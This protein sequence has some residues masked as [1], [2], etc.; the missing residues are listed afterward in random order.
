MRT[1]IRA[2]LLVVAAALM[3]LQVAQPAS[4]HLV[5]R[6][7]FENITP[8]LHQYERRQAGATA[9]PSPVQNTANPAQTAGTGCKVNGDCATGL[10]DAGRC[11]PQKG[12][13][14][15]N[16]FCTSDAQ[17]K[18]TSYC[19]RGACQDIKLDGA[20]CYKDSGC[21]SGFCVNKKCIAAA[22]Q[23]IN[24]GCT[25]SAQCTGGAFCSNGKCQT[26]KP[27]GSYCYKD[28]GCTS[29]Y[30]V[31]NKCSSRGL[32][33]LNQFCAKNAD[34]KSNFCFRSACRAKRAR[35][36]PCTLNDSCIS[37]NCRR[38]KCT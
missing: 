22:S 28:Q 18:T 31:N 9:I 20:N 5:D 30:C 16:S 2:A 29:G 19:Y 4:G 27:A 21:T 38:N 26:I 17:C 15:N 10:C 14:Q 25:S 3:A 7:V 6:E 36:Q 24:A 32:A 34:C 13:G 23:P 1:S 11:V 12:T 37:N 8:T 33:N 35:G